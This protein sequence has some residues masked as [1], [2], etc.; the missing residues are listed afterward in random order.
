MF[1]RALWRLLGRTVLS[2]L[3]GQSILICGGDTAPFDISPKNWLLWWF[4]FSP[5]AFSYSVQFT[6]W[7]RPRGEWVIVFLTASIQFTAATCH[8]LLHVSLWS[9]GRAHTHTHTHTHTLTVHA[10]IQMR[11]F[12]H[13]ST[14]PHTSTHQI[15]GIGVILWLLWHPWVCEDESLRGNEC[16]GNVRLQGPLFSSEG[17]I[18]T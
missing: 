8:T 5:R 13:S 10:R 6:V 9:H 14:H 7:K 17:D 15:R 3:D 1:S 18:D 12:T 4:C 16:E 11:K 2:W